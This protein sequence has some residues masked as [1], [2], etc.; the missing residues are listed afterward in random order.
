MRGKTEKESEKEI[1]V[2][3]HCGGGVSGVW[4]GKGGG[5]IPGAKTSSLDE[6]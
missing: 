6:P 1:V 2:Q 5:V 4:E 3:T